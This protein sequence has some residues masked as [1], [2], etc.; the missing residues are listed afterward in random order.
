MSL[1]ASPAFLS[2]QVLLQ[3]PTNMQE[4]KAQTQAI[5]FMSHIVPS[6]CFQIGWKSS[7]ISVQE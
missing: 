4:V 1:T 3:H 7:N 2:G 6:V 5:Q